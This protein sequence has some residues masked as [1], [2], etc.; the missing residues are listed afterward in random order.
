MEV[1]R[2]TA[3]V[4]AVLLLT[5]ATWFGAYRV[6]GFT[7]AVASELDGAAALA[8]L[9]P[10]PQSTIVYDRTGREAF[11]FFLEQRIDVPLDRVSPHMVAAIVSIE[12]RRFYDHRGLD[13][14]RIVASAWRNIRAG[15]VV[16]GGSTITQQLARAAQQLTPRRTYERKI[17]EAM[18]ASRLEQRYSKREILEAYLNAVYFGEGY[19]GVEAASRGYF[20]KAAADLSPQEAAL[21][22]AVVRSPSRDVPSVSP[23]RAKAR[24]DL[25]LRLMNEQHRLPDAEYRAAMAAPLPSVPGKKLDG[26]A[27]AAGAGEAGL[28]FQEELR[29]QLVA[30]FGSERVLRGG[31]RVY[32][33]YD[34]RL[35][36]LAERTI[37]TRIAQLASSRNKVRD[38]QGSLVAMDPSTGDVLALVGGHD[39][40]SSSFNRA[41]QARRQAGSAFKPIVFAAAL[42]RGFAPG[43]LLKELD[44]PII[45]PTGEVWL[46]AGEHERAEYTLRRALKL[47][48]NRAAAQLMQQIGVSTTAYY[49]Q[50]L[51]I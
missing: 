22:A 20:G 19:Y 5:L 18:I 6:V 45:T 40:R 3:V 26:V 49:A 29:R 10:R 38:L 17:R 32:S 47:S 34:P 27:V 46:P 13:P 12:D 31:L 23:V 8:E 24:R 2:R 51:G 39:F 33:T 16:A 48:S 15:R 14:V 4:S 37:S 11:T 50:R 42:E 7:R 21:L 30:Q 1:A 25:V 28:Y 43:T 44:T 41:T 9:T 36:Q 35:Q